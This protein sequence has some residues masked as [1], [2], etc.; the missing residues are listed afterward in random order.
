[1]VLDINNPEQINLIKEIQTEDVPASI[2][3]DGN[4]LALS[5]GIKGLKIYDISQP[6]SPKLIRGVRTKVIP[7]LIR[8]YGDDIVF[9]DFAGKIYLIDIHGNVFELHSFKGKVSDL[10][11][12][13]GEWISTYFYRSRLS[14]IYDPYHPSNI[15][16]M[17]QIKVAFKIFSDHPFFGVGNIDFNETYKKYREPFDKYTY[18]HLHNNYTHILATLGIFGFVIFIILLIKIFFIHIETI[19]ITQSKNFL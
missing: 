3:I 1:M 18:G 10:M 11:K 8:F 19:K 17:N 15:E 9:T 5:D 12:I 2:N 16:R 7:S 4:F 6:E 14:S 13:D